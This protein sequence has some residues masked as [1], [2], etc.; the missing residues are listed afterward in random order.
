[1]T[2]KVPVLV[3]LTGEARLALSGA[4]E[5]KLTRFPFRV[6]RESRSPLE[7][8]VVVHDERRR[9]SVAPN[10]DLYIWDPGPLLNISRE[11]FQIERS[12]SGEFFVRDRGS[13]CGTLVGNVRLGAGGP[14]SCVLLPDNTIVV[15]TPQSPFVFRFEMREA[16]RATPADE[17]LEA[18]SARNKAQLAWNLRS[19]ENGE[20]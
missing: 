13:T 7:A 15:G 2:G 20:T 12:D 5:L 14:E 6:G 11:H 1:M 8:G 9:Q 18:T 4:P 16:T 3:A 19:K 17:R 10:N